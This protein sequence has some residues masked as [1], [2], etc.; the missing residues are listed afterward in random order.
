MPASPRIT[1]GAGSPCPTMAETL[2]RLV[3][4]FI[5]HHARF[6]PVDATFMGLSGF[7]DRLPP[8]D[9]EAPAREGTELDAL[10]RRL[11]AV[12]IGDTAGAR[13]EVRMLRAALVHARAA[14]E[15]WPRHRQPSWY[16]GEAAFGLIALLLPSAPADAR[17]FRRGS[18]PF[19]P[20]SPTQATISKDSRRR[21]TGRSAPAARS[22]RSAG[23]C[24]TDCP[25]I[26]SGKSP[27]RLSRKPPTRRWAR[28]ATPCPACR[29]VRPPA[30]ATISPC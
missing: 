19:P 18:P 12:S 3:D 23:C 15:H 2:D 21:P 25:G 17:P 8:S 13:I 10:R 11:D 27:G 9:A 29:P 20:S 26:R 5:D 14:L 16:T 30:A 4:D 24:G 7:D 28:S 1:S 6:H 22:P